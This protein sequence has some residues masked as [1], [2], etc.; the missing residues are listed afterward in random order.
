MK[1][2]ARKKTFIQENDGVAG[3][4]VTVMIIGMVIAV[5]GIVQTIYVPQWMTER[6]AEHMMEVSDQISQIKHTLDSL[7]ITQKDTPVSSYITLGSKE[8]GF[9]SSARAFGYL[10]HVDKE[11]TLWFDLVNTQVSEDFGVLQY[12][13]QN[14]YYLDQ[15]YT[16]ECGALLLKQDTG[17]VMINPP[18]ITIDKD[19]EPDKVLITISAIQLVSVGGVSSLGG[20]GTYPIQF[21]YDSFEIQDFKDAGVDQEVKRFGIATSSPESWQNYFRRFLTS[22][23]YEEGQSEDF[24]FTLD[25]PTYNFIIDFHLFDSAAVETIM[26]L[27]TTA[28]NVQLAPG[29]VS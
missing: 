9:F 22:A 7:S 10:Q 26:K 4:I 1:I 12:S 21:Q 5:L 27:E 13:S 8:L 24:H 3:I 11:V 29:W 25:D 17:T 23:G 2:D 20:Y 28:I 16:I 15:E 19:Y 14:S 6:E 18:S